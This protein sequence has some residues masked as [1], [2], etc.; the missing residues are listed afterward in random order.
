MS[1][2]PSNSEIHGETTMILEKITPILRIFDVEKAKE[3]YVDFLGFKLDWE[4]RFD[5]QA[6]LY[7]QVSK[8]SCVLHLSEHYGD[9]SPGAALRIQISDI[10][11][12]QVILLGKNYRYSRPQIQNMP[13]GTRDMS[14]SD[15][16]GN[17][18]VL[19]TAIST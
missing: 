9:C 15:P 16:F 12:Y 14:I 1:G 17:R 5:D 4:H 8:D 18:L 7:M 10:E 3:F 19:T 11:Q 6:P 2:L 13:W